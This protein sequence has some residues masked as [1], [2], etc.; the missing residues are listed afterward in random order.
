MN[1][2]DSRVRDS[3]RVA[4]VARQISKTSPGP[5]PLLRKRP[6]ARKKEA[7][8]AKYEETVDA[9]STREFAQ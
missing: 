3:A 4:H 8:N 9:R 5:P 1:N 6:F 7:G 2:R